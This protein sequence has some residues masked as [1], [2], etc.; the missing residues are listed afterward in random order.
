MREPDALA[1]TRLKMSFGPSRK[2][3]LISPLPGKTAGAGVVAELR[4]VESREGVLGESE[5]R[6]LCREGLGA[7]MFVGALPTT[8]G[9]ARSNDSA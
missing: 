7:R 4:G 2:L 9:S 6:R 8:D 5:G 1:A 3:K